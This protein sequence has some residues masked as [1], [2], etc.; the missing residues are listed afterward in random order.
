[1]QQKY[2]QEMK[3]MREQMNHIMSLID[4]NPTLAQVKSEVLV[5]KRTE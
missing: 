4:Q 5:N 1:M 2:E 3:D